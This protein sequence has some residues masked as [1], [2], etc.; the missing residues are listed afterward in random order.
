MPL[1]T[2]KDLLLIVESQRRSIR[3]TK[4]ATKDRELRKEKELQEALAALAQFRSEKEQSPTESRP[5]PIQSSFARKIGDDVRS[6][7]TRPSSSNSPT[8][9]LSGSREQV[10]TGT[11]EPEGWSQKQVTRNPENH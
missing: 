3:L 2:V 8:N 6:F 4:E 9:S 5:I 11:P 7:F 10:E 1:L